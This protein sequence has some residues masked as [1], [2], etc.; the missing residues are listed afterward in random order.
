MDLK[1]FTLSEGS[2]TWKSSR[3]VES[4]LI[5]MLPSCALIC[6]GGAQILLSILITEGQVAAVEVLSAGLCVVPLILGKYVNISTE[7]P[8]MTAGA[9][10]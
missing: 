5:E 8:L 10:Q 9:S 2:R 1:D 3:T 6:T 7:Q 4:S